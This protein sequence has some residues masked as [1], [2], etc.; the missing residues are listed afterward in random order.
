MDCSSFGPKIA[1]AAETC[2]KLTFNALDFLQAMVLAGML[3]WDLPESQRHG[4]LSVTV[5]LRVTFL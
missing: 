1:G 3:G 5:H 2:K 4:A